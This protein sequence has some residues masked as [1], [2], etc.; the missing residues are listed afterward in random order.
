MHSHTFVVNFKLLYCRGP[1]S[2]ASKFARQ[3]PIPGRFDRCLHKW[4]IMTSYNDLKSV[5]SPNFEHS[6]HLLTPIRTRPSRI[7]SS[8]ME[9]L[10]AMCSFRATMVG[11]W[12]LQMRHSHG[13]V[14]I[15][16]HVI[17]RF[18]GRS[19]KYKVVF[20]NESKIEE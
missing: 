6:G 17:T 15:C 20:I 12:T 13:S 8:R 18:G 5:M 19:K 1:E 11:K 14:G 4:C 16:V 3:V 7:L 10:E 9:C 2:R